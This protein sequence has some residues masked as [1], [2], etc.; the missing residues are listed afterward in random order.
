MDRGNC[1]GLVVLVI[2]A[3]QGLCTHQMAGAMRATPHRQPSLSQPDIVF[4]DMAVVWIESSTYFFVV[5]QQLIA[6]RAGVLLSFL[7]PYIRGE[8]Y[9]I[10]N[11][12][13][14]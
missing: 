1:G 3:T 9:L 4:I 13:A 5:Q 7:T 12:V 2:G 6:F 10:L 14:L 8:K 11:E